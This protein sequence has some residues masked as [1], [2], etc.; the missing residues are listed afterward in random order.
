MKKTIQFLWSFCVPLFLAFL[1]FKGITY[2]DDFEGYTITYNGERSGDYAYAMLENLGKALKLDF[3]RFYAIPIFIQLLLY[4]IVFRLYKVNIFV[5]MFFLILLNYV[6]MANQLRYFIAFPI[7]LISVYYWCVKEKK[8]LA[9]SLAVLSFLFHSGII[10]LLIYFPLYEIIKKK[11]L[12]KKNIL[13]IY[14]VLGVLILIIFSFLGQFMFNV[15]EKYSTYTEREGASLAGVLFI[16]LYAVV[17]LVLLNWKY[18]KI[19][20]HKQNEL[21]YYYSLSF[22]PLIFIIATFSRYQIICSRYVDTFLAVW[23]IV[24]L[25]FTKKKYIK[26]GHAFFVL[27]MIVSFVVK[28]LLPIYLFGYNEN[29][30]LYKALLI[31]ASKG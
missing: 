29:S 21:T 10:A 15:D 20:S 8:V 17:C 1:C 12:Q 11:R 14:T 19:D 26:N 2:T 31:W 9:I 28:Y 24:I 25:L 13:V 6:P 4:A 7:F 18:P 22:F 23:I 5:S 16:V 27:F 30:G 3:E